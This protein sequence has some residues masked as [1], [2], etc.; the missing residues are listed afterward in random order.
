M[1]NEGVFQSYGGGS[2]RRTTRDQR[3]IN[4]ALTVEQAR[5]N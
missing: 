1:M 3:E 2:V 4:P 5:A